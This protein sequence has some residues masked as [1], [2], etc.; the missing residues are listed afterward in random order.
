MTLGAASLALALVALMF[1]AATGF[2]QRAAR[3]LSAPV[4]GEHFT[5]LACSGKPAKRS[6]LQMEGCAEHELLALDRRVNAQNRRIFAA[7]TTRAGRRAFVTANASWVAFRHAACT[8]AT[9]NYA[10]GS[11]APL[12][13]V[14]CEQRMDRG[15][16]SELRALAAALS[17]LGTGA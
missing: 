7:L 1:L 14:E 2:G 12:V 15:H 11:I 3:A 10:G 5:P 13:Y 8:A 17:P 4:V 16:L 9:D 6:T